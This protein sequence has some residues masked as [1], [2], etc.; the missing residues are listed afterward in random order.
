MKNRFV[1][2]GSRL[3]LFAGALLA[4]SCSP[5]TVPD[6]Q[7]LIVVNVKG[8]QSGT[9]ALQVKSSLDGRADP[10]GLTITNNTSKFA[11]QLAN[12]PKNYGQLKLDGYALDNNQCY[13]ANGQV[14]EQITAQKTYYELDLTLLPQASPKC[15][16]TVNILSTGTETVTSSPAGINCGGGQT[17]CS[18]DFP[19]GTAVTLSGPVS[20]ASYPV[21]TGGC[22]P[23]ATYY[24]ATCVA[25]VQKGNAS[26]T[27]DF[28]PRV[29]SPDGWCQ[30][31]PLGTTQTLIDVWGA[32]AKNLWIAGTSGTVL[33][34][35]GGAWLPS[36]NPWG[37]NQVSFVRG[38]NASNVYASGSSTTTSLMRWDGTKWTAQ[39]AL[40]N[41][42]NTNLLGMHVIGSSDVM[43]SVADYTSAPTKYLIYRFNGTT[44][45]SIGP[46]LG[47]SEY[48]T[49][50]W[51]F[52]GND[53]WAGSS[54][55][56]Y[57]FDGTKWTKDTSTAIQN[58]I[59][60]FIWGSA[61][62][63]VWAATTAELFH[64][65]GTTWTAAAP[66]NGV[67]PTNI[68]G[69]G[70]GTGPDVWVTTSAANGRFYRYA[71]GSCSPKCWS[72]VDV[73]GVTTLI[74]SVWG[75]TNNDLWA[76]GNTGL[77]LHYDGQTWSR[78]QYQKVPLTTGALYA[79]YGVANNQTSAMQAYGPTD[80]ALNVDN[81]NIVPA[82]GFSTATQSIFAA[83]GL[84]ANE[85]MI[86]GSGG[87]GGGTVMRWDGTSWKTYPSGAPN[88]AYLWGVY[89]NNSPRYYYIVGEQGY[90]ARADAT[91]TGFTP[92][93]K[94][95]AT[96]ASFFAVGGSSYQNLYAV[97]SG[98]TVYRSTDGMNFSPVTAPNN[99][100]GQTYY[101]AFYHPGS[102]RVYIAG[103]NGN[104]WYYTGAPWAQV[105]TASAA[106]L[107]GMWG[108]SGSQ[109]LWLAGSNGTILKFDGTNVA[110]LKTG[111]TSTLRSIWGN[112]LTDIWAVG[113]SGTILRWKM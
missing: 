51:G 18:Y 64:W 102:G 20:Q 33:S 57:H 69:I 97:G 45:S 81:T 50:L 70:G 47:A 30:Y 105:N 24:S 34:S 111:T 100:T 112:N 12:D 74:R 35:S 90:I 6:S 38:T 1:R 103:T 53:V 71:G 10:N 37:T 43:L 65:D 95:V 62:N 77:I 92:M 14:T 8:I 67:T 56:I 32:D 78:S 15:S 98:G 42:I 28:V 46:T 55:G 72:Q 86:V 40:P 89:I 36:A 59:I 91:L 13:L 9:Q 39:P 96:S 4:S 60:Q 107:Y 68:L 58:K 99:D 104:L 11:I 108:M 22:T 76:V 94:T 110:A 26:A 25:N 5:S 109:A 84:N 85:I 88:F 75:A 48:L 23:A 21:W 19:F 27:V 73:T 106:T 61:T 7:I 79:A 44:Y 113:L 66:D 54:L 31:H 93:T 2:N 29:C 101:S 87:T 41:Q 16:L 17:T 63:D 49:R 83:Y 82:N 3:C 80:T 52:G